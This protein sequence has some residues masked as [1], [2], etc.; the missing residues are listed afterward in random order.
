[1]YPAKGRANKGGGEPATLC[2]PRSDAELQA[3]L[4]RFLAAADGPALARADP[5][6]IVRAHADPHDQEVVGMIVAALAYGRVASIKQKARSL[7][8]R[9]GPSPAA[10]VDDGSAASAA[11]GFVHR[12][13]RGEDLPRFLT[14]LR[15]VRAAHGSLAA[16]FAAGIRPEE[17]DYGNA[18]DRFVVGLRD[19]IPPPLSHGE[20]Y[21]LPRCGET[22]GAA[23][24][25]WLYL[26]WMIRQPGDQDLGA[27]RA[28]TDTALDPSRLVIPLDTHVLRIGRYIGL[29]ERRTNTLVTARE[30]TAAL[31]RLRPSDPLCY[32]IA[33]CHLGISGQCPKRREVQMCGQCPIR[34][35][36]R[37]GRTPRGWSALVEG[38]RDQK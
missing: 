23:K 13:Q 12:F 16:A 1:M 4:D 32:D 35:V 36:C 10:A 28:L 26:R 31:R 21:L 11:G 29:T 8:G 30:I 3:V 37:L 19:Q 38:G 17:E 6:E 22:G 15:A 14:A 20:G 24:R 25:M 2:R 34:A 9:L 33:L 7:L 27:W 18:L 5:V